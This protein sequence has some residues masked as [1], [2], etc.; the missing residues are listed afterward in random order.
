[1]YS[2]HVLRYT[3]FTTRYPIIPKKKAVELHV[4]WNMTKRHGREKWQNCT[5]LNSRRGGC[6]NL[7]YFRPI[8]RVVQSTE[9]CTQTYS[10]NTLSSKDYQHKKDLYTPVSLD[11][12]KVFDDCA[13]S[14]KDS[15]CVPIAKNSYSR[16]KYHWIKGISC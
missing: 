8:F 14:S 11:C 4:P 3:F 16:K 1:M 6:C 10:L 15:T 13:W 2:Q 7:F 12:R 5:V 9:I